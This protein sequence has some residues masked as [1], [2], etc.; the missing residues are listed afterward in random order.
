MRVE[1]RSFSGEHVEPAA[2]LL[3][4]RHR[5][6]RSAE[7]LLPASYE[8]VGPCQAEIAAVLEQPDTTI[9]VD[10]GLTARVDALGNV[11]LE[12]G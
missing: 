5:A 1:V 12:R 11:I 7:P 6:H 4:A 3:A 2:E 8:S 9:Y 10:P